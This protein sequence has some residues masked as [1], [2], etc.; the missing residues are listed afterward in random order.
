MTFSCAEEYIRSFSYLGSKPGLERIKTLLHMMGDPQDAFRCVHVAGTNGKGSFCA[1]LSSVLISA[2]YAVGLYSTPSVDGFF[3]CISVG[4]NNVPDDVLD[5][6]A[7]FVMSFADLMSDHPTEYELLTAVAFECFRRLGCDIVVLECCMG[8]REDVTN[9]IRSPLLSVITGV[10]LDHT[11]VLGKTVADIARIKAGI[12]KKGSPVLFGGSSDA[13]FAV[14]K[15]RAEELGSAVTRVPLDDVCAISSDVYGSS[16][17]FRNNKYTVSLPG[18][19]QPYN[20]ASVLCACD[21]ISENGLNI[22]SEAVSHGLNNT[23]LKARFEMLSS[24][25]IVIFDGAHNPEGAHALVSSAQSVL[26]SKCILVTGIMKDKDYPSVAGILSDIAVAAF[27]CMPDNPRALSADV[28]AA[29]F[30]AHS[31]P[32]LA[33]NSAASAVSRAL[34]L[35]EKNGLPIVGTGSLY[36]YKAFKEVFSFT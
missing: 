12:I 20:A 25:P 10:S 1:M 16:F 31:V 24:D 15:E 14:I 8:G 30:A 9:V 29:C 18:T 11:A 27:T 4:G 17:L 26:K 22:P 19:Y 34:A 6:S 2:G 21:I 33:C 13:A 3:G 32:A 36:M 7:H 35:A 23:R 5:S 28:Y